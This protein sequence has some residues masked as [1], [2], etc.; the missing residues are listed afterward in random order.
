ME[1]RSLAPFIQQIRQL[2]S[3]EL[4][5][6]TELLAAQ[7]H[8]QGARLIAHL[9]EVSS[10]RLHLE[11][12][13]RSLFE[14]CTRCLGLSEGCAALR[15]QVSRVCGRHPL[16]LDA[17]AGQRISV[18]VAGKLAPHLTTGNRERLIA[19]CAGMTTR[20]VQEYLVRLAPKPVVSPG[21][22]RR[23]A[24][25][26]PGSVEPCQP[27]LYNLRFAA[28]K[29][30]MDEL[31]RAAEVSGVGSAGRDMARV[32]ERALDAYLEKHDPRQR[33]ERREKRAA[34]KAR[35]AGAA[36]ARVEGGA[37]AGAQAGAKG[38]DVAADP[39]ACDAAR[40]VETRSP[41]HPGLGPRPTVHRS[42]ASVRVPRQRRS[43][44]Q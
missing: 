28:D 35:A 1:T 4:A 19:D 31:E 24:S 33:Q 16:I 3:S 27:D 41:S 30:F 29:A 13:H 44:L 39:V 2:S 12:G 25:E 37:D 18:T 15:I 34:Q 14:Y 8:L 40:R 20:E 22:R 9:A 21:A 26:Q 23:S 11:R 10:R 43:S 6:Q 38:G 7:E 42:G 36:E 32:F 5:R 17:L